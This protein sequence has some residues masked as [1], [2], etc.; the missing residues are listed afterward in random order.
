MGVVRASKESL[1]GPTFQSVR[2]AMPKPSTQEFNTPT[3]GLENSFSVPEAS[4]CEPVK[5]EQ[6]PN[7][8]PLNPKTN[9]RYQPEQSSMNGISQMIAIAPLETEKEKEYM[10]IEETLAA[11]DN[12]TILN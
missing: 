7:M 5:I 1:N 9:F 4:L 10:T 11:I 2:E 8:P 12:S 3:A 6:G